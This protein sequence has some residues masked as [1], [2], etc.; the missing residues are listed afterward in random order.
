MSAN[1]FDWISGVLGVER[2]VLW[3]KL[4]QLGAIWLLGWFAG[5]LLHLVARRI[6]RSVDNG[7]DAILS[8]AEKRGHTVA[9]LVRSVGRAVLWLATLLLSLNLFADIKP[10]LAGVGI[11][12]LT[13]SFGAQSLVKDFIAGFF[14]LF[15]NQFV[16]GDVIQIGE[17]TGTVERMTLR[18]VTLR[19]LQ[20]AIHI[21]P[22][23]SIAMVSNLTRGWSRAVVDIAVGYEGNVDRTLDVVRDELGAFRRDPAWATRL[24]GTSEVLG[25]DK[26]GDSGLTIRTLV[27][28]VAGFQWEAAREFQRRLKNRFDAEGIEIPTLQRTVHLRHHGAKGDLD[29]LGPDGSAGP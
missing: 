2:A 13:I 3:Q 17:K 23:G 16:V 12:S 10:L 9:Q 19:D 26:L 28:T 6:E 11:L 14:I 18:I 25:I 21:I 27:R 8:A 22:N 4:I 29:P 7:D 1:P 15:E 20:G 24:E 5:R